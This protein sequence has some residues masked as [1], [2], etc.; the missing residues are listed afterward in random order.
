MRM[1]NFFPRTGRVLLLLAFPFLAQ[2]QS[3]GVGTTA[4]NASAALD[5]VS[6]AKGALLPRLTSSPAHGHRQPGHR[7]DCV[8]DRRH[9][10]L[11][12]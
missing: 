5:V 4:P 11:L 1:T 3:V 9:A 10:R 7:P 2:A 12:L 8:P 6:S